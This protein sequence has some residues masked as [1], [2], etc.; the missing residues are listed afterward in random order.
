MAVS[1]QD[2]LKR[3]SSEVSDAVAKAEQVIDPMLENFVEG[4]HVNVDI[5]LLRISGGDYNF[6]KKVIEVILQKYRDQGW[7]ASFESEQREGDWL[8]FS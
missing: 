4:G 7:T 3:V 8:S 5:S 6:H 2:V 1:K